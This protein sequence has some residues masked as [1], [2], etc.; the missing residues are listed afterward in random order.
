MADSYVVSMVYS[1]AVNGKSLRFPTQAT[2]KLR[3]FHHSTF[4]VLASL[5]NSTYLPIF[6]LGDYGHQNGNSIS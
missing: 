2:E 4:I 5:A 3:A 6:V 1:S